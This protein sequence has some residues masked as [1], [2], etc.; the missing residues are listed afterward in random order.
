MSDDRLIRA[1]GKLTRE[2]DVKE[3]QDSRWEAL[4]RGELTDDEVAALHAENGAEAHLAAFAPFDA[5]ELDRLADGAITAL[6]EAPAATAPSTTAPS[7][8]APAPV[9]PTAA[10]AP[11]GRPDA[12]VV[13]LQPRAARTPQVV[14]GVA[15]ALAVAAGAFF[16]LR[17]P[18]PDLPVYVL[19]VAGGDQ[20]MRGTTGGAPSPGAGPLRLAPGSTLDLVA[21]P[22]RKATG[23]IEARAFFVQ[24]GKLT[25]IAVALP[26]SADGAFRLR[27]AR[28]ILFAGAVDG[29]A[30]VLLAVGAPSDLPG[31]P[32]AAS[33]L[34]GARLQL[35]R[36]EVEL[37]P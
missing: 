35:L 26:R 2:E 9:T 3:A 24:G 10:D 31:A 16:F 25:P 34:E 1:L 27:A 12:T 11:A 13:P 33:D 18:A 14:M 21:R 29:P 37:T 28:E 30:T 23:P 6:N 17:A 4:T 20:V 8:A 7:D 36:Q 22:D 5:A 15:L 19:T 32:A